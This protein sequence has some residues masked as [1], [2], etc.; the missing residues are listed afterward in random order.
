[1]VGGVQCD[2]QTEKL[3]P[4]HIYI[5]H[6]HFGNLADRLTVSAFN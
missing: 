6:V 2:N 4:G 5:L 1:M 3:G